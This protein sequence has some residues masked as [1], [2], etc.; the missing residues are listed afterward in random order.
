MIKLTDSNY[1]K[2][3]EKSIQFGR[4]VILENVGET[5]DAIL[6]PILTKNIFVSHG[7]T[8]LKLGENVLEYSNDFR[9]YITTSLRN[10]HYLPEI[11]VKVN[12]ARRSKLTVA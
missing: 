11:A 10:P 7:V 12:I 9:F 5:I 2:V 1:V 8:F 3:L 4:P 6:D